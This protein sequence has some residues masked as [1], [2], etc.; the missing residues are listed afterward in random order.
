[1]SSIIYVL[2]SNQKLNELLFCHET[3]G[4]VQ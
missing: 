1:V 3:N 2:V 4:E